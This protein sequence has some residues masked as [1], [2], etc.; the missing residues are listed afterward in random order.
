MLRVITHRGPDDRGTYFADHIGFGFR[1]LAILDITPAGHQPMS[2]PDGN[3]TIV[4]NGEIYNYLEL[5]SE[6]EKYGH[7][8]ISDCDT[9]V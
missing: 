2:S 8:F 1:R 5:R 9:E 3:F 6:L 7:R 4:F